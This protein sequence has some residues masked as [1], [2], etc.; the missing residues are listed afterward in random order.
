MAARAQAETF[1]PFRAAGGAP[2]VPRASHAR[3]TLLVSGMQTFRSRGLYDRYKTNL[4]EAT[5]ADLLSL[6]AG[7]WVPIDLALEHYR[8][9]DRLGLDALTIDSIG[10]EV[11]D[12]INK[13]ALSVMVKMSKEIGVTPWS[14][15]TSCHRVT[16]VNWK[17]SDVTVVKLGPKDARYEWVGQPCAEVPYF[18]TSFGG[19]LRSLASLFCTRAYTRPV[20]ERCTA[21][22]VS[23]RLSWV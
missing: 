8:A 7:T 18:V 16:D 3:S 5:R 23:Y 1:V 19:F 21:S 15:L 20:P 6:I 9:A 14:A 22:S 12:R 13:T 11:A 17:G 2:R 4:P 10:A